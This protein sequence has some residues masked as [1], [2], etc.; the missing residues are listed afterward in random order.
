MNRET[1]IEN[2]RCLYYDQRMVVENAIEQVFGVSAEEIASSQRF[3]IIV[4]ARMALFDLFRGHFS[5]SLSNLGLL[6]NRHHSTVLYSLKGS[7]DL[8]QFDREYRDHY[9]RAKAIVEAGCRT[10]RKEVLKEASATDRHFFLWY[11]ANQDGQRRVFFGKPTRADKYWQGR[12]VHI[13][14]HF[15]EM[16]PPITWDDEPLLMELNL[17]SEDSGEK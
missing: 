2:L 1:Q 7:E 16:F 15:L 17:L 9:N 4:E 12:L 10:L 5:I 3:R 13:D 14:L 11:C 6:Y 8:Y